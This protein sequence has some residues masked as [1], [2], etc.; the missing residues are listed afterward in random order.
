MPKKTRKTARKRL[1]IQKILDI[2]LQVQ[3]VAD[4]SRV[5]CGIIGG[6]L[7]VLH[8]IKGYTTPDID[9]AADGDVKEGLLKPVDD[10]NLFS[11]N[12]NGH[13]DVCGVKVDFINKLGDGTKALYQHAVKNRRKTRWDGVDKPIYLCRLVDALAIRMAAGRKKDVVALRKIFKVCSVSPKSVAR[14][15]LKYAPFCPGAAIARAV[16]K[17]D[18]PLINLRKKMKEIEAARGTPVRKGTSRR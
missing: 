10:P 8:G 1:S 11:W 2:A 7:F 12:K 16:L 13:Y 18:G 3:A 5:K 14:K 9:Y 4:A 6:A 17:T 15:V